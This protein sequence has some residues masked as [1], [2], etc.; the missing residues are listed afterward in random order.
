MSGA[1]R[2]QRVDRY[3]ARSEQGYRICW[4]GQPADRVFTAW[5][6]P[7]SDQARAA[8]LGYFRGESARELAIEAC[9][10]HAAASTKTKPEDHDRGA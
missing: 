5:A 4:A 6:P 8:P 7:A 2:W 3:H 10:Q 1:G 9:D